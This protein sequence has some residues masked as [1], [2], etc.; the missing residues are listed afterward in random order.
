MKNKRRLNEDHDVTA[1]D[2]QPR[3]NFYVPSVMG[4]RDVIANILDK[5]TK[6]GI[7]HSFQGDDLIITAVT[8]SHIEQAKVELELEITIAEVMK[9]LKAEYKSAVG[10]ALSIGKEESSNFDC[11]SNYTT[12]KL[13]LCK[14][15]KIYELPES[16]GADDAGSDQGE[17]PANIPVLNP[18]N[19]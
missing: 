8:Y 11:V 10:K 18:K 15:T 17:L 16:K 13:S 3:D 4:H 14:L 1:E 7:S 5:F 6:A 2:G 19:K 12:N 9:F